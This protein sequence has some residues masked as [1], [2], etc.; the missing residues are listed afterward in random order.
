MVAVIER[1][2][3]AVLAFE[4]ADAPDSW[5]LPQGG[6]EQGEEAIDA[7]WREVKEETGLGPADLV[8]VGEYP[9]WVAYEWPAE[10]RA[11][12]RG[13]GQVQRWFTFRVVDDD[14]DTAARRQRVHRLAM[15]RT[16]LVDRPHRPVPHGGVPEG[17][18]RASVS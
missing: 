4:R 8:S 9:E 10:I 2:D 16:P 7:V 3:G 13:I 5:Q 11:G 12:R 17:A 6:I 14:V 1:G 15:G 18:R